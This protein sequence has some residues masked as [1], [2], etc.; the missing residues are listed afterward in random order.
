MAL[1]LADEDP[2]GLNIQDP[3]LLDCALESER[4]F[5]SSSSFHISVSEV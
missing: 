3:F 2:H 1:Q 5:A 4:I